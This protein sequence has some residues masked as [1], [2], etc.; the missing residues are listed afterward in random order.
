MRQCAAV[1]IENQVRCFSWV[2]RHRFPTKCAVL[3][4]PFSFK[5]NTDCTTVTP[6]VRL[7]GFTHKIFSMC[8]SLHTSMQPGFGNRRVHI[9][10]KWILVEVNRFRRTVDNLLFSGCKFIC[11]KH[12]F[13][14]LSRFRCKAFVTNCILFLCFNIGR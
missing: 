6:D 14:P 2:Y 7:C 9:S 8:C 3:E 1:C 5:V 10:G 11:C 12:Q 13:I 4:T